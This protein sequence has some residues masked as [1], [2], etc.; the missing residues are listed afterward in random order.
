M[1]TLTTSWF[2]FK[3]G[4]YDDRQWETDEI[5][6]EAIPQ[7][8]PAQ[9]MYKAYRGLGLEINKALANTLASCVG[10]PPPFPI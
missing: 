10:K 4:E 8:S 2:N 3:T 9:G 1:N 6:L 5:A 7:D